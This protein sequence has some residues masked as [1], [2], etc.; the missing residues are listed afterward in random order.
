MTTEPND[1]NPQRQA[2]EERLR[3][4]RALWR[5]I[6]ALLFIG[7]AIALPFFVYFTQRPRKP[8]SPVPS[9]TTAA[10]Q[11][12][13]SAAPPMPTPSAS[14]APVLPPDVPEAEFGTL[15]EQRAYLI[16]RIQ[17]GMSLDDT[18]IARVKGIFAGSPILSQGNPA[19]SVRAMTRRECA[20]VRRSAGLDMTML[21]PVCGVPNMVPIFNPLRGETEKDAHVCIDQY[22]F[23][24]LA[25]EYP[26]V[27]VTAREAAELCTAVGKRMCD[28]HEWE[29]ACAG[30]LYPAEQEYSW[31]NDVKYMVKLHGPARDFIWAY[32]KT[33]DHTKCATGS[34]KTKTCEGGGYDFCGTNTYPT[35]AFPKCVSPFGV[36]DLHGNAAEHMNRPEIRAEQASAG[37]YGFTEMKGSW[38]IFTK[39]E[40]HPDDC[41]W[42]A[43]KWHDSRVMDRASHA[44]YHL[45]FR[46][47]KNVGE[48]ASK[49]K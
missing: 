5:K 45:G 6:L 18:A 10:P 3:Q 4:E 40:A 28:T 38:F 46:C 39:I 49:A 31:G 19:I 42:R 22:E 36:Y 9:A 17:K 25:C 27:H 1:P 21:H 34:F 29:G 32:G 8:Q 33:K 13:P 47:C 12:P 30:A 11:A 26:V 23:P 35:G 16:Q 7:L 15:E 48:G 2:D 41:R 14:D 20:E 44:N 37:Q 24:N 43:F